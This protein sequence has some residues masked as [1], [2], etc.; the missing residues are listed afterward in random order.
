MLLPENLRLL[1]ENLRL[2]AENLELLAENLGLLAE[3]P[4]LLAGNLARSGPCL[5][6]LGRK[7]SME[8]QV[9]RPLQGEHRHRPGGDVEGVEHQE[10]ALPL[11][12]VEPLADHRS[13]AGGIRR[14]GGLAAQ[15]VARRGL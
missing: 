6:L 7:E 2:L 11:L 9:Q 5:T 15:I 10:G 1:A 4:R 8:P 12:G 3:N 14:E 13:P